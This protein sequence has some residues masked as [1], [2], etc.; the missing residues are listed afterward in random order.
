MIVEGKILYKRKMEVPSL[1][2]KP[3]DSQWLNSANLMRDPGKQL[4]ERQVVVFSE[5]EVIGFEE[6]LRCILLSIERNKK[7]KENANNQFFQQF[8]SKD[9]EDDPADQFYN[10]TAE[11]ESLTAKVY[12]LSKENF[13]NYLK[14]IGIDTA[15]N[16]LEK[17]M[18]LLRRQ[19]QVITKVGQEQVEQD[20]E[21]LCPIE[22]AIVVKEKDQKIQDEKMKTINQEMQKQKLI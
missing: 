11:V 3:R 18:S 16:E 4:Q 22:Q 15:K 12:Y 14:Y 20:Y 9:L 19:V 21:K 8:Q 1:N 10:F 6:M 2:Q 17:R 5:S 7:A 13:E